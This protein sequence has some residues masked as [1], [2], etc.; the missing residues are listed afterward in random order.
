M[1]PMNEEAWQEEFDK[2]KQYPEYK[3]Y[4][5]TLFLFDFQRFFFFF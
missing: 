1:P 5:T 4:A 2:Y 3:K